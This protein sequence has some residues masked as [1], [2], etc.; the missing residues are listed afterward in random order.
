MKFGDSGTSVAYDSNGREELVLRYW[1]LPDKPMDPTRLGHLE[2]DRAATHKQTEQIR[3]YLTTALQPG[4][5]AI[6][7]HRIY[8]QL[9]SDWESFKLICAL[10]WA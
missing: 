2:W 4:T 5:W 10:G 9:E 6:A 3:A 1:V 8:F 7:S